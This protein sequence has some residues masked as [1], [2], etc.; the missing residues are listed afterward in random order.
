MLE[1]GAHGARC[2]GG[3]EVAGVQEVSRQGRSRGATPGWRRLPA[4]R[5]KTRAETRGRKRRAEKSIRRHRGIHPFYSLCAQGPP[6]GRAGRYKEPLWTR[7]KTN[8]FFL[9][10]P[11]RYPPRR[12]NHAAPGFREPANTA[13]GACQRSE[14]RSMRPWSGASSLAASRRVS[15]RPRAKDVPSR[16]RVPMRQVWPPPSDSPPAYGVTT[17]CP[18][19]APTPS[20]ASRRPAASRRGVGPAARRRKSLPVRPEVQGAEARAVSV[21]R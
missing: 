1:R 8:P 12:R 7:R 4:G 21:R 9:L 17:P 13:G 16:K 2:P 11:G 3:G 14:P 6:P 18:P 15:S 5:R 10:L 20:S 19:S